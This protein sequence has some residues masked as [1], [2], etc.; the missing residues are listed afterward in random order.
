MK[1][2]L[3]IIL[4]SSSSLLFASKERDRELLLKQ[5]PKEPISQIDTEKYPEL[6]DFSEGLLRERDSSTG[7]FNERYYTRH[8]DGYLSFNYHFSQDYQAPNKIQSFGLKYLNKKD[9]SYNDLW[10]A[11][12]FKYTKAKYNAIAD[13]RSSSS[14]DTNS[15]ASISRLENDQTI[16]TFGMG[17]AYR[18]KAL[19]S[20]FNN[21][22]FFEFITTVLNYNLHQDSTD[23]ESYQGFGYSA[24]Y[25][26]TY[27]ITPTFFYGG[28]IAYNWAFVE[29]AQV[30]E[31][32]QLERSLVFGW[33][34]LGI[35]LGYMF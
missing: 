6:Y 22:R 25:S 8:D 30:D 33:T 7:T 11:L 13:E 26:L 3:F 31:E 10:Y 32:N 18:F 20:L 23:N 21:S 1:F 19:T 5:N 34:A 15:V 24:E 14:G 2:I 35:E 16:S 17:L 27:R 9:D 29:R 12:S 28:K 4:L